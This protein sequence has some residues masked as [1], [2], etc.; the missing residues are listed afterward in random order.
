MLNLFLIVIIIVL[1]SIIAL[2]RLI[3]RVYEKILITEAYL[4]GAEDI[5]NHTPK[6]STEEIAEA[7]EKH[8]RKKINNRGNK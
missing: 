8:I 2:T 4:L 6:H 3:L 1:V 5:I 7:V